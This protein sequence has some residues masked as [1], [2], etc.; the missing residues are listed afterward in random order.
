VL[1]KYLTV[2]EV[3]DTLRLTAWQVRTLCVSGAIRATKPAGKWLVAE[4]D[5]ANYIEGGYRQPAAESA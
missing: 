4:T 2:A 5:L 3:A 1:A